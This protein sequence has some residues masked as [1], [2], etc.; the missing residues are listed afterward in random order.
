MFLIKVVITLFLI[1]APCYTLFRGLKEVA[2]D[3]L[4]VFFLIWTVSFVLPITTI[5]WLWF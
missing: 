3:G 4:I 1:S 2:A 5:F